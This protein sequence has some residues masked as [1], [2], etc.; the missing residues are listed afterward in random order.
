MAKISLPDVIQK[1]G[2]REIVLWVANGPNRWESLKEQI[3]ISLLLH[4]VMKGQKER[5]TSV[6]NLVR[7]FWKKMTKFRKGGEYDQKL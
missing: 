5:Q 6:I 2:G 4:S 7:T 3:F 1:I